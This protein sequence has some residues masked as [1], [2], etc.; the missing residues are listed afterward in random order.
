MIEHGP[1][2][3]IGR[4]ILNDKYTQT[5]EPWREVCNR[6]AN[7]LKDNDDHFKPLREV[8]LEMRFLPGGR[9]SANAGTGATVS[10]LLNCFMS[11]GPFDDIGDIHKVE[12]EMMRTLRA[13]GGVGTNFSRLRPNG[14][15]VVRLGPG[16]SSSGPC[17]FV[18]CFDAWGKAI[19]AAGNRRGAQMGLLDI[20]HP[21]VGEFI[22]VKHDK[23]LWTQF[24]V[25]VRVPDA[26]IDA[27]KEGRIWNYRFDGKVAGE[28]DA[29]SL[30]ETIMRSTYDF[31]EPGIIFTD[32]TERFNPL[33]YAET[34]IGTNPCG[35]VPLP[36]NGSC[37]LGSFVLPKYIKKRI[38]GYWFDMGQLIDD[39][40]T[41]YPAMDNVIDRSNYPLDKQ[42]A[43]MMAK[44]RIGIGFTGL[45]NA[46]EVLGRP[47]GSLA[48]C[49]WAGHIMRMIRN[50]L[51]LESSKRAKELGN[52]PVY[53]PDAHMKT[54]YWETLPE[55]VKESVKRNGL[56]NS[57]LTA[58]A[59]TGTMSL[60]ADNV[61]SGIEPVFK[62]FYE[63]E[64]T[65]RSGVKKF[66]IEDYGHRVF[67]VKGRYFSECSIADHL[68]VMK[69]VAPI[70]D[71]STSK[72]VNIPKDH[73]WED[74]K[75][76]Y[77]DAHEFGLKSL[78]TFPEDAE[79]GSVLKRMDKDD[80]S[81]G[82][83]AVEA[84]PPFCDTCE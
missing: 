13:G 62:D 78:A 7:H 83:A 77:K 30:W 15:P 49:Q 84:V 3:E 26:F 65:L 10:T 1:V 29:R 19:H 2:T 56:R 50:R 20:T 69:A 66:W 68:A 32:T 54:E 27:V 48:F 16:A 31:A 43:E 57:H 70:V 9:I 34:I 11:D 21:D 80:P 82:A 40:E 71:Q 58:I 44:R 24:N 35:E 38:D 67:G 41:I 22:Q 79:R 81:I 37:L 53:D 42:A 12:G 17:A 33:N 74:F 6:V 76:I 59:P 14:Y 36:A 8:L 47:Y 25:S 55:H 39:I 52:F 5:K 4:A 60:L 28:V 75:D 51:Y 18:H 72:T 46:G 61:S 45:A 23:I 73:P 64:V 63:R